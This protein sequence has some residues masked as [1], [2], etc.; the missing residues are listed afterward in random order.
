MRLS[1]RR[2]D[3]PPS[4]CLAK[5]STK[6][7]K[8]E[9]SLKPFVGML[10]CPESGV[11]LLSA[12]IYLRAVHTPVA[13]ATCSTGSLLRAETRPT[14]SHSQLF[15][16]HNASECMNTASFI[17]YKIFK[18]TVWK[19]AVYL[20]FPLD[21]SLQRDSKL[22]VHLFEHTLCALLSIVT[23]LSFSAFIEAFWI[24]KYFN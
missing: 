20:I 9:I 1:S 3:A 12:R 4:N 24:V 16:T 11:W 6:M 15:I 18:K 8:S 23:V 19:S 5:L 21:N 2:E 14:C 22:F 13:H 7:R 17:L 10:S